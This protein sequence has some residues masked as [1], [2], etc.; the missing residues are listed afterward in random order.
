MS[1]PPQIAGTKPDR[2]KKLPPKDPAY[3]RR[4]PKARYIFSYGRALE[5]KLAYPS[6]AGYYRP[7]RFTDQ[8]YSG[9]SK[10]FYARSREFRISLDISQFAYEDVS[11]KVADGFVVINAHHDVIEDQ[12][13]KVWR[14]FTRKYKLPPNVKSNSLHGKYKKGFLFLWGEKSS[15]DVEKSDMAR[16]D[17]QIKTDRIV[18][19]SPRLQNKRRL[20]H[21]LAAV[22]NDV[23]LLKDA[24]LDKH[25]A[26]QKSKDKTQ[27]QQITITIAYSPSSSPSSSK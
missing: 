23:K 27:N 24:R 6:L 25:A 8:R 26:A 20:L 5:P 14:R 10:I 9:V 12:L 21:Q 18:R 4:D 17:Q 16:V 22:R 11:V 19:F 13:G 15:A 7:W 1:N 2:E 3:V